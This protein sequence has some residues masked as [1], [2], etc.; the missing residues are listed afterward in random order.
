MVFQGETKPPRLSQTHVRVSHRR[1]VA[2]LLLAKV[3]DEHL[4]AESRPSAHLHVYYDAPPPPSL[5]VCCR[6][7]VHH[8]QPNARISFI[9]LNVFRSSS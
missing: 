4:H 5:S 3:G 2:H 9:E 8:R 7:I 6:F 1:Q